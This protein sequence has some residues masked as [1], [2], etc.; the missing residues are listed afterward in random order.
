MRA[1]D[2]QQQKVLRESELNIHAS[3]FPLD[4]VYELQRLTFAAENFALVADTLIGAYVTHGKGGSAYLLGIY[5]HVGSLGL[6]ALVK[7]SSFEAYDAIKAV[8]ESDATYS[9]VRNCIL[10]AESTLLQNNIT[11]L[12]NVLLNG[13]RAVVSD[14][15][16]AGYTY[17]LVEG[18]SQL[19]TPQ[20][21]SAL[22]VCGCWVA[23]TGE[24]GTP[25][26]LWRTANESQL[27]ANLR[28]LAALPEK[29]GTTPKSAFG[30]NLQVR[31]TKASGSRISLL[32]PLP[33]GSAVP[34]P[35][36]KQQ[37]EF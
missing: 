32:R 9:K 31:T 8:M 3:M 36:P 25:Y 35:I 6:T 20:A 17:V 27:M 15:H 11:S 7:Y 30:L 1:Q 2:F 10:S 19:P 14:L 28:V 37:H 16:A 4:H 34:P 26:L 12:S 5:S 24:C 22:Q 23:V 21:T 13:D 29:P 33:A 18:E